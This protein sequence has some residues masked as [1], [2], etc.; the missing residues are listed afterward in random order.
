M[1]VSHDPDF[2]A[3]LEPSRVLMMPEGDLDYWSEDMLELVTLA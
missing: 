1:L 2:V 3:R